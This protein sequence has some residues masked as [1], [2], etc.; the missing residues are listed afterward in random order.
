MTWMRFNLG[1][2]SGELQ[3]IDL[4]IEIRDG[5]MKLVAE[6][7]ASE[8]IEVPPGYYMVTAKLP[9]GQDLTT[10]VKAEGPATEC[11]LAPAAQDESPNEWQEPVHYFESPRA[12]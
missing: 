5:A 1:L 7:L 6:T 8:P 10:V 9:A 12:R 4:P 2:H 3:N 11:V